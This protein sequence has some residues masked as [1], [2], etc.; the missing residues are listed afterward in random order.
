[1]SMFNTGCSKCDATRRFIAEWAIV[2]VFGV[3]LGYMAARG[4]A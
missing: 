1:M 2:I 4:I 3:F